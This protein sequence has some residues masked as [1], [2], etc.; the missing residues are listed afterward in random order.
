[1]LGVEELSQDDQRTVDRA[2]KLE[3]FFTQ[4]F[5]VTEPFTGRPGRFVVL[6]D[7]LEGCERILVGD[8]DDRTE[9]ELYMIGSL[10]DLEDR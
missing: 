1:M 6:D 5:A 7:A 9:S 4:P 8:L 2:R 10:D 3:R